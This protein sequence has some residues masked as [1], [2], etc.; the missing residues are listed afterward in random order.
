MVGVLSLSLYG[1]LIPSTDNVRFLGLV[2]NRRL[3]WANHI[4]GLKESCKKTV[5][6]S[7]KTLSCNLRGRQ[8][9]FTS[10]FSQNSIMGAI[11][12]GQ[13]TI[14]YYMNWSLSGIGYLD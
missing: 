13:I 10:M 12:I 2:F 9:D 5:G 6:D 11:Y 14:H 8:G 7:E 4:R 3:T 1:E